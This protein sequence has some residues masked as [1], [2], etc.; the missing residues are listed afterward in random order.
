MVVAMALVVAWDTS[1]ARTQD[2]ADLI[3][4]F[5]PIE[6]WLPSVSIVYGETLRMTLT[7]FGSQAFPCGRERRGGKAGTKAA[8]HRPGAIHRESRTNGG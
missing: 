5:E 1:R 7:N 2:S 6:L 4:L 3:D 8:G